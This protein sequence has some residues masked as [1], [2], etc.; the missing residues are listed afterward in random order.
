MA[1]EPKYLGLE[2]HVA[3]YKD[4]NEQIVSLLPISNWHFLALQTIY[5]LLL[6]LSSSVAHSLRKNRSATVSFMLSG[7]DLWLIYISDIHIFIPEYLAHCVTL[8]KTNILEALGQVLLAGNTGNVAERLVLSA[9]M[10]S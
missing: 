3:S 9:H 10:L 8:R 7:Q 1:N 6:W 5:F 2:Q 4:Q